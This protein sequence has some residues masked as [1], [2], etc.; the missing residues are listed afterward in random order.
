M[1]ND[2]LDGTFGFLGYYDDRRALRPGGGFPFDPPSLPVVVSQTS[3][4]SRVDES[5][6]RPSPSLKPYEADPDDDDARPEPM[7]ESAILQSMT[8]ADARKAR[9]MWDYIQPHLHH[10]RTIPASGHVKELLPSTRV[11]DLRWNPNSNRSFIENKPKDISCMIIQVT[12]EEAPSPCS[13][14]A[15]GKGIFDSCIVID[16][17]ANPEVRS[18]MIS[19]ANCNYHGRQSG[20][21]IKEWVQDREQPPYPP[22]FNPKAKKTSENRKDTSEPPRVAAPSSVPPRTTASAT[23]EL[24]VEHGRTLR[25]RQSQAGTASSSALIATG[26]VP[27]ADEMEKHDMEDWEI[28]PGRIRS[29]V[30][31]GPDSKT[32]HPLDWILASKLTLLLDIAMSHAYLGA[33][34]DTQISPDLTARLADIRGGTTLRLNAERDKVRFCLVVN[35]KL[36]VR[37]D[38]EEEFVIGPHGMFKV[39][40]GAACT[41]LNTSYFW[42]LVSIIAQ[43]E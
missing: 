20:C 24:A 32:P 37:I 12:G 18:C 31:D 22:Y 23:G 17:N 16:R 26:Q 14:C 41:A 40:P 1:L 25:P 33:S 27:S 29:Q 7:S 9:A 6:A 11:R 2:N 42:A 28:A 13:E 5:P 38:G 30:S 3:P 34:H 39:R 43:N 4:R 36:K 8:P 21:S 35:G 15:K 10:T 19:C